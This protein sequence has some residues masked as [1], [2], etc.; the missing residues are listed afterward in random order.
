MSIGF[1]T[2]E[3]GIVPDQGREMEVSLLSEFE[4][5]EGQADFS[6]REMAKRGNAIGGAGQQRLLRK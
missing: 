5:D 3:A 6:L 2:D 1:A 4:P